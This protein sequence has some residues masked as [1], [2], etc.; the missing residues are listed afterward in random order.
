MPGNSSALQ[1]EL[2][3]SYVKTWPENKEKPIITPS[4]KRCTRTARRP[5]ERPITGSVFLASGSGCVSNK[6]TRCAW[7]YVLH[8]ET[9]PHAALV[10][11][12]C[13]CSSTDKHPERSQHSSFCCTGFNTTDGRTSRNRHGPYFGSGL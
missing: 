13:Q 10:A 3:H 5:T 6:V 11:Y 2:E 9:G 7:A 1:Y 8:T 12:F 4:T